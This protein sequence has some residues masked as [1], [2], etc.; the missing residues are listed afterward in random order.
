MGRASDV[1]GLCSCAKQSWQ[2]RRHSRVIIVV[3]YR[4]QRPIQQPWR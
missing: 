1:S 2:I 4:E 3:P